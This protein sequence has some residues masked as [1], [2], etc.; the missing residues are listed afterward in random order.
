MSA[1]RQDRLSLATFAALLL[2]FLCAVLYLVGPY[3]LAV[4]T[5]GL[6]ALL[7]YPFHR[8]LVRKGWNGK[9]ASFAVTLGLLLLVVGPLSLFAVLAVR[10]GISLGQEFVAG[11][12]NF[13]LESALGR[14]GRWR[15]VRTLLGDP[16]ALEGQLRTALQNAG[17]FASRGILAL[18]ANVPEFLLQLALACLA[19]FFLLIDGKR[20]LNWSLRRLPLDAEVRETLLESFRSTAVSTVWATLAAAASQAGTIILGFLLLGVPGAFFAA[21]ATFILAWIPMVGSVPVWVAGAVYLYAQES[22]VKAGLMIAVGVVT[23]LVD[24]VVR[25]LVL[26]G[27]DNMHP[28]VSLLAIFGGIRLFGLLGVF[29][30]PI[31]A[32]LLISLLDIWPD[33]GRRLGLTFGEGPAK[34][35]T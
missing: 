10:E 35:G 20:F 26:G 25:P 5:G 7:A 31:L 2:V 9:A 16:A 21:G 17:R 19:C 18:A 27:R 32:A 6:L 3:L 28:L 8:W 24:N 11:H 30:G 12:E 22:M 23:G 15:P 14:A 13:S 29:V 4:F 1:A 33:V 34:R